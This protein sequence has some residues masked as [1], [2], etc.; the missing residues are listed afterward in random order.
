MKEETRSNGPKAKGLAIGYMRCGKQTEANNN[1][2]EENIGRTT[3]TPATKNTG[4]EEE[5]KKEVR[6][7][8]I[9]GTYAAQEWEEEERVGWANEVAGERESDE[10]IEGGEAD[11]GKE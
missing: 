7:Q 5:P 8:V 1:R 10:D 6:T 4:R 9:G 11:K 3:S 2:K